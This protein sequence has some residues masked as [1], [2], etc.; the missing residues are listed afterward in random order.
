VHIQV[1]FIVTVRDCYVKNNGNIVYLF[2]VWK[3]SMPPA[4]ERKTDPNNP[5][6]ANLPIGNG[7][8]YIVRE[9]LFISGGVDLEI[10]AN[11]KPIVVMQKDSYFL[12]SV[13][14]NFM[15]ATCT[16]PVKLRRHDALKIFYN[17]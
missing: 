4:M 7:L 10:K 17:F 13:P 6:E 11:E 2:S 14:M 16:E 5:L 12:F 3:A 1:F 9:P 15:P 8:V